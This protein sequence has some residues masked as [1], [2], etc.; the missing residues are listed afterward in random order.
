MFQVARSVTSIGP[1]VRTDIP[2][3]GLLP[4]ACSSCVSDSFA[5]IL[6]TAIPMAVSKETRHAT[7][8]SGDDAVTF[9]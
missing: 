2:Q 8:T 7:I 5:H 1:I 6:L 4:V 3:N 9:P